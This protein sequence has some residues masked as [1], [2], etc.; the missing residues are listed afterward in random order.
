MKSRRCNDTS[1]CD[2]RA[3][4]SVSGRPN[5]AGGRDGNNNISMFTNSPSPHT[6]ASVF[7]AGGR[8]SLSMCGIYIYISRAA[9][10]ATGGVGV[11]DRVGG[12]TLRPGLRLDAN[13][14]ALH[15]AH[16]G[17]RQ[18]I[19]SWTHVGGRWKSSKSL[20][21]EPCEIRFNGVVFCV[22][23]FFFLRNRGPTSPATVEAV[24]KR[25]PALTLVIT[26]ETQR[27]TLIHSVIF[28]VD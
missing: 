24:K 27:N 16:C 5:E 22:G 6:G 28:S 12:Q 1:S 7:A 17:G 19:Q 15:A 18:L 20:N 10:H 3:K 9:K 4:W 23:F 13:E 14:A 21:G 2:F 25:G 8:L 26:S 11:G